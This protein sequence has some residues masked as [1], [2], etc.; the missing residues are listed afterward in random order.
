MLLALPLY[1]LDHS[2]ITMRAGRG[3]GD[4]DPQGWDWGCVGM[5][6]ITHTKFDEECTIREDETKEDAARRYLMQEVET[7]DQ[8]IM[9]SVYYYSIEGPHC[10]DCCGGFYGYEWDKNGLLECAENAID[11]EI[12]YLRKTHKEVL[13]ESESESG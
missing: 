12:E 2:G 11:C 5:I 10:E 3:F 13:D 8:Y 9:G 7:Y 6:F 4:C 1:L